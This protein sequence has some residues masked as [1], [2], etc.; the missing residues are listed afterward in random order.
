[1]IYNEIFNFIG[2]IFLL[3]T[4]IMAFLLTSLDIILDVNINNYD[5]RVSSNIQ[6]FFKIINI[7]I[8]IYPIKK[9]SSTTKLNNKVKKINRKGKDKNKSKIKLNKSIIKKIKSVNNSIKKIKIREIYSDIGFG[10][11]NLQFTSFM[12]L[13]I[14][15]IY[16]NIYSLEKVEKLYLNIVPNYIENYIK[17]QIKVHIQISFKE[18]I[19]ILIKIYKIYISIKKS[20]KEEFTNESS[21]FNKKSHGDNS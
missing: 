7:K 20:N 10:N 9:K 18:I 12:Y 6:Y 2:Y 4:V 21:W 17:G 11:D 13:F 15:L 19:F 1:M 14:N 5:V 3:F 8:P 16:G